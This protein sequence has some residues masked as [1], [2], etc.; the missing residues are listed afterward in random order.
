MT[1]TGDR[2][3]TDVVQ[4]YVAADEHVVPRPVKELAG[5]AKIELDPGETATATVSLRPRAFAR[6]DPATSDWTVDPG[7]YRLVVAASAADMRAELPVEI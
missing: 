4:V 5:F 7:G 1:N 2:R 6:W 3:G